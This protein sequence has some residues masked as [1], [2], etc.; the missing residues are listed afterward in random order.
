MSGERGQAT[1]EWIGI[2]LLVALALA[3]LGRVAPRTESRALGATIAHSVTCAARKGCAERQV[4]GIRSEKRNGSRPP[5]REAFT[6]PPLVPHPDH[7]QARRGLRLPSIRS[8][9]QWARGE[10]RRGL[11]EG[12]RRADGDELGEG[13]RRA[14]GG[15]LGERL[16][17]AGGRALAERLRRGGGL[18]WRRAWIACLIYERARYAF[19][20]PESRFPGYTIPPSEVLRMSND[21]ISPFDLVRD[22]QA[23]KSR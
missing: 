5:A 16:R 18:A 17:R 6:A 15:E 7:L 8:L 3:A 1:V 14:A 22:W 11:A 2:V 12:L 20:H 19:L 21:C 4:V 13:L 9:F 10:G 23:L